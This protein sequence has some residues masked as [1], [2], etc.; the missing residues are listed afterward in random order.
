[1][2]YKKWLVEAKRQA[3]RASVEVSAV[4]WLLLDFMQWTRTTLLYRGDE[5]ISETQLEQL[6]EALEQLLEGKPVQYITQ[7]ASFYGQTFFVDERVLIPRPETEEVVEYFLG[8]C[9]NSGVVADIGTGSG[10]IALTIKNEK[11]DLDVI[12]S[13]ISLDALSVAKYNAQHFHT[14]VTFIQGDVLQPFITQNIHLDGLISNPPYIA[15]EEVAVMGTNVIKHEPHLA[16]FADESGYA[17]YDKILKDLPYVM[18]ANAPI[19]FEIGY[20]QGD[21]LMAM[22]KSRYP[23]LKPQVLNDINGHARI[24]HMNWF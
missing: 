7:Q 8:I 16:L 3:E 23:D 15:K 19:V 21:T 4:E 1:M 14:N 9:P 12:A 10:A 13:D 18:N 6:T 22:I 17:I 24:L 2:S 20:Q 5:L 11:K